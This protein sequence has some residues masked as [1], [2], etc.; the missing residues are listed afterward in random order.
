MLTP[1]RNARSL[2]FIDDHVDAKDLPEAAAYVLGFN[3][4]PRETARDMPLSLSSRMACTICGD[5]D[6]ILE[7]SYDFRAP[8]WLTLMP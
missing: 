2:T 8:S 3:A 7:N 6:S 1:A 5:Q 4:L